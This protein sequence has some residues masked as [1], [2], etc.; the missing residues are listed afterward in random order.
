MLKHPTC[1][2]SARFSSEAGSS[3]VEARRAVGALSGVCESRLVAECATWTVLTSD[4]SG[5]TEHA[6]PTDVA[7]AAVSRSG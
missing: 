7:R 5:R 4:A 6:C 2:A 1:P 3:A